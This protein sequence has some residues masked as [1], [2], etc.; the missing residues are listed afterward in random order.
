MSPHNRWLLW[1]GTFLSIHPPH[2]HSTDEVAKAAAARIHAHWINCANIYLTYRRPAHFPKA[3][4]QSSEGCK[5]T[6]G[7]REAEPPLYHGQQQSTEQPSGRQPTR[8]DS[9][10]RDRIKSRHRSRTE[11]VLYKFI[12]FFFAS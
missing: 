6:V 8:E 7:G 10:E 4:L 5:K 3:L 1:I 11:I 2:T 12:Y 9:A